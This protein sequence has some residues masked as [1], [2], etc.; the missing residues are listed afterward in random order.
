MDN[1]SLSEKTS[2]KTGSIRYIGKCTH[3]LEIRCK[4]FELKSYNQ[5]Y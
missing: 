4:K 5:P 2:F 1:F 3:F